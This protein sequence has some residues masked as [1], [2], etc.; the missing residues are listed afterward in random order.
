M[1]STNRTLPNKN[2]RANSPSDIRLVFISILSQMLKQVASARTIFGWLGGASI[3]LVLLLQKLSWFWGRCGN[4]R[5]S[6]VFQGKRKKRSFNRRPWNRFKI[7]KNQAYI[8]R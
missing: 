5:L 2:Y 1:A 7:A 4:G 3:L 8:A 6:M